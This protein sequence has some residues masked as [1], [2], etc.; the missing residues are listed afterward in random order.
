[1]IIGTGLL[2]GMID[3]SVHDATVDDMT[4]DSGILKEILMLLRRYV[5]EMANMQLVT[6]TGALVGQLAPAMDAQLGVI[7]RR[8]S[9]A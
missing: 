7:A 4:A 3:E 2:Q 6:D 8:R 5:P 9:Y 1:M